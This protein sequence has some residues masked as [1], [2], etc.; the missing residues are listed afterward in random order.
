MILYASTNTNGVSCRRDTLPNQWVHFRHQHVSMPHHKY[1]PQN[2]WHL[3]HT[4]ISTRPL[5]PTQ[6]VPAVDN[7][8]LI[9]TQSSNNFVYMYRLLS[10]W[11]FSCHIF[12]NGSVIKTSKWQNVFTK[13]HSKAWKKINHFFWFAYKSTRLLHV[14]ASRKG[15]KREANGKDEK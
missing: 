8:M 12:D 4:E 6:F 11:K 10:R 14:T 3:C 13:H 5:Q 7:I 2:G 1:T 9:Y 15:K